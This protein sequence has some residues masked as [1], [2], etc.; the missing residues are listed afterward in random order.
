M[1]T[2]A[3]GVGEFAL[4]ALHKDTTLSIPGNS[5]DIETRYQV[6]QIPSS[7]CLPHFFHLL[8]STVPSA[9]VSIST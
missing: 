3:V 1:Q 9:F 4:D 6:T 8:L 2:F 7:D 5:D